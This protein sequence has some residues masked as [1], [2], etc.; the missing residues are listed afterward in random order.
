MAEVL[1][2]SGSLQKY[3]AIG[4]EGQPVYTLA[5]QLRETVRLK[6]G[7]S[8]ADCL[9]IPKVNDARSTIDWYSPRQGLV[10]PWST[11]TEEERQKG[12]A[13]LDKYH[14][15]IMEVVG[16][17]E[18]VSDREKRIVQNLLGKVFHFP[19]KDCLFLVGGEPVLT[20][21]GFTEGNSTPVAD[22]FYSLRSVAATSNSLAGGPA[23]SVPQ[24]SPSSRPWW[25]WLLLLLLLATVIFWLMRACAPVPGPDPVVPSQIP[26]NQLEA[27]G[28]KTKLSTDLKNWWYAVTGR[29]D[30]VNGANGEGVVTEGASGEGGA[31]VPDG[32][33]AADGKGDVPLDGA[34][35]QGVPDP[36]AG[37]EDQS[38]DQQE[39]PAAQESQAN[40]TTEDKPV[41]EEKPATV[42]GQQ[43]NGNNAPEDGSNNPD[44]TSSQPGQPPL[45]D[46]MRIPPDAVQSGSVR[47]LDGKWRAAGGLQDAQT[48]QPVRLQYQFDNGKAEVTVDKGN[49]I[50]CKG[51]SQSAMVD[52]KLRISSQNTV[53]SCSDG[54]TFV[55][56]QI[57][58]TPDASGKSQCTGA[59]QDGRSLPIT[60]RQ[61]P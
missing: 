6:I 39:G 38:K 47:F 46:P 61:M 7:A 40:E 56:P 5:V 21:W 25:L 43:N 31:V 44:A 15:Q 57:T 11:A 12:L 53:T 9:A 28:A 17:L 52:G 34:E 1:L 42:D 60:I 3:S 18:H 30:A 58:C 16:K 10:V 24:A 26:E 19:N 51:S 32:E 8:A 13:A 54:S 41:T 27:P 55:L 4:D 29:S 20:F 2:N 48:G 59:G 49:G 36:Q 35:D 14:A 22:P 50:Q 37:L 45:G 33:V 23:G